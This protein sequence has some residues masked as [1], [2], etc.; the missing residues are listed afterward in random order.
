MIFSAGAR[1]FRIEVKFDQ[2]EV[3]TATTDDT[4]TE[5][6]ISNVPNGIIGFSLDYV[7]QKCT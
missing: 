2:N 1:P 5:H 3:S 7:Q 6:G 4:T